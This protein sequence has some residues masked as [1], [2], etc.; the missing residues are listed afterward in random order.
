MKKELSKHQ[1]LVC[2]LQKMNQKLLS[3][4][5]HLQKRVN[6][7]EKRTQSQ[8]QKKKRASQNKYDPI[9][10]CNESLSSFRLKPKLN[11]KPSL[12]KKKNNKI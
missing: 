6:N 5:E 4:V 10:F 8:P 7:L 3:E 12:K 1:E 2:N 11:K 9:S